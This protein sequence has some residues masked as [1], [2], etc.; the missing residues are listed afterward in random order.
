MS[1]RLREIT[2]PTD[3]GLC[4][5]HLHSPCDRGACP[6]V[7][8]Y[9]DGPGIRPAIHEIAARLAD[10]GYA[11]LLPDLFYRAGRYPPVDPKVVFTD[12]ALK[13][14]HRAAD[15]EHLA[16]SRHDRHPRDPGC[17]G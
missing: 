10:E 3:D 15:V 2:V 9:M 6:R 8:L 12:P 13:E 1:T 11:A 5:V 4:P 16:G 17:V 14:A 7:I